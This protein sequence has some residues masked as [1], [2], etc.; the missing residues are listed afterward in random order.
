MLQHKEVIWTRISVSTGLIN[1][2]YEGFK[3]KH[4]AAGSKFWLWPD[5]IPQVA[6][7]NRYLTTATDDPQQFQHL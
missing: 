6:Q 2:V 3:W 7:N 5:Q 1:N 4:Q